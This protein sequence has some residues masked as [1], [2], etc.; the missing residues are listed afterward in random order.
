MKRAAAGL[1]LAALAAYASLELAGPPAALAAGLVV[2]VGCIFP[3][4]S[5]PRGP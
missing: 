5:L 2:L 1:V 3:D 4:R